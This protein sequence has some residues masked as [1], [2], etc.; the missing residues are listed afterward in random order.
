MIGEEVIERLDIIPAQFRVIV[1]RR[2]KYACRSCD[3][4]I[5]QASAPAN[6][7]AVSVVRLFGSKSGVN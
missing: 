1:T 5:P 4:G 7:I 6:I 3:C 2:P